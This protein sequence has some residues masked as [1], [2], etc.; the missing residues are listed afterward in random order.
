MEFLTLQTH[1]ALWVMEFFGLKRCARKAAEM[2]FEA[3]ACLRPEHVGLNEGCYCSPGYGEA[4]C[5]GFKVHGLQG[6]G[7]EVSL[8]GVSV[9]G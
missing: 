9:P 5:L 7:L 2:A 8:A 4:F 1:A 3:V 6:L